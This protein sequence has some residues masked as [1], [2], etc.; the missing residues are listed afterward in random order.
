[1]AAT[2]SLDTIT[3]S[4]SG[5]TIDATKTFTVNGTLLTTGSTNV[6]HKTADY[7]IVTGDVAGKSELVV[8]ATTAGPRNI[9]LPGLAVAGASTCVITIMVS[10]D[11]TGT[12]SLRV[13]EGTTEVWT[14]YQKGDFVR[15]CISDGAWVVL[16]HKETYYSYRYL[17][18][19]YTAA[20]SANV[21]LTGWTEVTE[22]GNA[23]DNSNNK[24]ITPTGMN[25]YWNI[26]YHSCLGT[27]NENAVSAR[28]YIGGASVNV[29]SDLY[30]VYGYVSGGGDANGRYYAT[31]T[32]AVEFYV[33][34]S[35]SNA[36]MVL[37]GGSVDETHFTAEFNR[38]Y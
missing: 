10:A 25:G 8:T 16:D 28:L 19:D 18:A 20:T 13:Q 14:G 9:T 15:L 7:P 32:Q 37:A 24:L 2:L 22:I 36:T 6:L 27:N 17:T 38:V 31:S 23:W 34:N 3:S 5:I 30:D 11:A 4:G 26:Y 12:D 29:R 1:M 35:R 21:K 33:R